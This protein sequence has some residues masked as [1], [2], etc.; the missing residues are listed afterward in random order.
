MWTLEFQKSINLD[1]EFFLK[2]LGPRI[3][4]FRRFVYNMEKFYFYVLFLIKS[5]D[6]NVDAKDIWTVLLTSF[7]FN[8]MHFIPYTL[9]LYVYNHIYL[10]NKYHILNLQWLLFHFSVNHLFYLYHVLYIMH[11]KIVCILYIVHAIYQM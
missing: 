4:P 1:Q 3:L 7:S 11:R 10:K 5:H 2:I 6:C 8:V 9:L